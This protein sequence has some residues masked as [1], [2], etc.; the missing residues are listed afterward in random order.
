MSKDASAV[1]IDPAQPIPLYFQ[2]KT[3]LL[4]QILTGR[5]ELDERL[6]TEYELCEAYGVSRTPVTRALTELAEEGVVLRRRRRGTFVNPHWLRRSADQ[7]EVRMVLP[8]EGP[9]EQ[10]LRAGASDDVA[11]NVV[12]VPRASLYEVLTRAV[13]DGQAPD[14]AVLDSAW[15]PEFAAAGFLHA[16]EDLDGDWLRSEYDEDF[17]RPL[18]AANRYEGGTF[19]VPA[20][21]DVAG[22]WYR[23]R[24]LAQIGR[25]PPATWD[26]LRSAARALAAGRRLP[27]IAMPGGSKAGETT[28]YCLIAFLASNGARVLGPAGVTLGARAAQAFRF[29]RSLV[30]QGLMPADV[31]GYEWNRSTR[32]LA[33]GKAAI[34]F[35]GSYEARALADALGVPLQELAHHAGFIPMPGGPR[36]APAS[37]AGTMVFGIFRQAAQPRAAM[38]LLRRAVE[39]AGLVALARTTGRIPARRSAVELAAPDLPFV[40][41]TADLLDRAVTRPPLPLYPR[42]SAQLQAAL[43]AVLIGQLGAARAVRRAGELISAI[44]GLPLAVDDGR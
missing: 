38:R 17:L 10:M 25:E 41:V 18:V 26:E 27:P 43:E 30:E 5:Y 37:L 33:Q 35:G 7:R 12:T 11:L 6:P 4:E 24:E 22:L 42:V 34:S 9:W 15:A 20:F 44:T 14:I 1:R 39:P 31:V 19:A 29:L 28:T 32:L 21:G 36:G 13:A 40:S 8:E 16:L 23:R 3:L 2:V